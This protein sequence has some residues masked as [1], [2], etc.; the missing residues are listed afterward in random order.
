M[1]VDN[2]RRKAEKDNLG[3][4]GEIIGMTFYTMQYTANNNVECLTFIRVRSKS[5]GFGQWLG[6]V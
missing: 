4:V 1:E 3:V 5:R 2:A 6:N